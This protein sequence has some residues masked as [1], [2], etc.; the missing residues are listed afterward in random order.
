MK[1]M[2]IDAAVCDPCAFGQAQGVQVT[3]GTLDL[4]SAKRL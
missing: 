3:M 1:D 4:C 2:N